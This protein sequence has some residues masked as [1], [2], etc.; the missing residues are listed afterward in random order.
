MFASI[1]SFVSDHAIICGLVTAVVAFLTGWLTS[2]RI[3]DT[4]SFQS[5][6]F[7]LFGIC[8]LLYSGLFCL[9]ATTN[10]AVLIAVGL[11]FCCLFAT[12]YLS[13]SG[14]FHA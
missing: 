7:K 12:G 8:V 6:E 3:A 5:N 10:G 2:A 4:S 13:K 9:I 14:V 1:V 11:A